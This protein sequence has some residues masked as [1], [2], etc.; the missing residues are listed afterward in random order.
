M[1]RDEEK[2]EEEERVRKGRGGR[3]REK[4]REGG[5]K[6]KQENVTKVDASLFITLSWNWHPMTTAIEVSQ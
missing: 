4:E 1:W 3:L 2:G 5:R 6:D